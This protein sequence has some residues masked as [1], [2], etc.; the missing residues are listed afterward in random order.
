MLSKLSEFHIYGTQFN[1][2]QP[3]KYISSSKILPLVCNETLNSKWLIFLGG[4]IHN[5]FWFCYL[6]NYIVN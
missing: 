2:V 1:A 4:K 5:V 3:I 6:I